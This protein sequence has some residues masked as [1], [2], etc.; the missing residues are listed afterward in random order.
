MTVFLGLFIWEW[1]GLFFWVG[2][3]NLMLSMQSNQTTFS[4]QIIVVEWLSSGLHGLKKFHRDGMYLVGTIWIMLTIF[5][6]II[7]SN[8][9]HLIRFTWSDRDHFNPFPFLKVTFFTSNLCLSICKNLYK[10]TLQIK[11]LD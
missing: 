2:T 8:K 5:A 1:L 7:C 11:K 9:F 10:P 3:I 4:Y 6:K